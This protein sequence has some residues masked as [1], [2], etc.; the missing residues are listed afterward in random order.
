MTPA[1][2][3]AR[4]RCQRNAHI[5]LGD[6]TRVTLRLKDFLYYCEAAQQRFLDFVSGDAGDGSR[7]VP[8][9]RVVPVGGA[10][11]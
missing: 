11:R 2:A 5:Q 7:A 4:L 6:G 1:P 8:A 3:G 9:L 10:M